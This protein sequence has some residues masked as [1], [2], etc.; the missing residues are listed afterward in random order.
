M[1]PGT[2]LVWLDNSSIASWLF[3][4]GP[5]GKS[6]PTLTVGRKGT[7]KAHDRAALDPGAQADR[8]ANLRL[9]RSFIGKRCFQATFLSTGA[10]G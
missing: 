9:H 8:Q 1:R 7:A 10:D 3:K 5:F 2:S 6:L 4:C